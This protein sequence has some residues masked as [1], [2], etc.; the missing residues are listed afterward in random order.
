MSSCREVAVRRYAL[1]LERGYRLEPR[2]S[3]HI[4]INMFG[5]RRADTEKVAVNG[6]WWG[7]REAGE[8]G[9]AESDSVLLSMHHPNSFAGLGWIR[10]LV[11]P[12]AVGTT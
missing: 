9:G 10:G 1:T 11:I 2:Q 5:I 8:W 7:N 4:F 6:S 12:E 3:I